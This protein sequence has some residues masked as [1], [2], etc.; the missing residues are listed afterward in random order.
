MTP[1]KIKIIKLNFLSN[2]KCENIQLLVNKKK[3]VKRKEKKKKK[4]F[5]T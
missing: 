3:Q 1:N 2:N 5:H 4:L